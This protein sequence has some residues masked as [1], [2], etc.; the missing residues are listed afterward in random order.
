MPNQIRKFVADKT[1]NGGAF[2][3]TSSATP[4]SI[5]WDATAAQIVIAFEAF[6][7]AGNVQVNERTADSITVECIGGLANQAVELDCGSGLTADAGPVVCSV[8]AEG[9]AGAQEVQTL[10]FSDSGHGGAAPSGGH[11]TINGVSVQ[12]G[13]NEVMVH[14]AIVSAQGANKPCAVTGSFQTGFVVT[15]DGHEPVDALVVDCS[16]LYHEASNGPEYIYSADVARTVEGVSP[17]NRVEVVE[18]PVCLVGST[19][20]LTDGTNTTGD[21]AANASSAAVESAIDAA[22]FP[23]VVEGDYPWTITR[24][25]GPAIADGGSS[26]VEAVEVTA[27]TLQEGGSPE[28]I[29]VEGTLLFGW[30]EYDAF[31]ESIHASAVAAFGER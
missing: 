17:V 9:V 13:A 19:F 23:C 16:E 4:I 1:P 5:P 7:G 21:I 25:H 29:V 15:F 24:A 11:F 27:S 28:P 26:L 31:V 6:F 2:V 22:L 3:F 12:Y 8:E 20:R 18:L 14:D 10:S 30:A